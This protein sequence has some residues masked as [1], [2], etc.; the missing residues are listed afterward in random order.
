MVD[1]SINTA[2]KQGKDGVSIKLAYKMKVLDKLYPFP[3]KC[4]RE[5][6]EEKLKIAHHKT[7]GANESEDY[8]DDGFNEAFNATTSEV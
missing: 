2:V 1:G 7:F 3:D 5:V 4:Q 8:E 6:E